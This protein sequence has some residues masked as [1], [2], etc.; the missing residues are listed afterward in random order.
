MIAHGVG[1]GSSRDWNEAQ[2]RAET[3][4][5]AARGG[6][7][8]AERKLLAD[9]IAAARARRGETQPMRLVMSEIFARMDVVESGRDRCLQRPAN[10]PIE[11]ASMLPKPIEFPLLAALKKLSRRGMAG[12]RITPRLAAISAAV[13]TLAGFFFTR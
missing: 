8:E 7:G 4:V 3:Y 9:A 5:R 10:P 11:R 13:L 6:F 1:T 2:L 12:V